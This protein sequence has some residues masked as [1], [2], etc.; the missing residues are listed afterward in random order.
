MSLAGSG[1]PSHD[2][3]P[4]G[5]RDDAAVLRRWD[6]AGA[7]WRVVARSPTRVTVA[8]C[9]CDGGEEVERLVS[10]DPALLAFLA[11]RT[12]SLE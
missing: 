3:A 7:F 9:T 1:P 6:E 2:P 4:V 10:S 11:G 8:M 12:S 5:A